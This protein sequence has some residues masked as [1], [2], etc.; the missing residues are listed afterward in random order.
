MQ[1]I[2]NKRTMKK[3][4]QP[5]PG[6]AEND[7]LGE[8]N[9][10]RRGLSRINCSLKEVGSSELDGRGCTSDSEVRVRAFICI[11]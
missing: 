10:F 11:N 5:P 4:N 6:V 3:V 2:L 1:Y 9:S 7:F 8:K